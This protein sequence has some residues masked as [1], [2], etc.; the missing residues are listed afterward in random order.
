MATNKKEELIQNIKKWIDIDSNIKQYNEKIKLSR[1]EK[2]KITNNILENISENSPN[3]TRIQLPDG[4][5]KLFTKKEYS[6]LTFGF[7][8]KCLSEIIKDESQVTYIIEY[9]KNKREVS[10]EMDIRRLYNK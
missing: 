3:L 7:L 4:E 5:L 9:I 2:I 8:E 6:S 1:E 10:N